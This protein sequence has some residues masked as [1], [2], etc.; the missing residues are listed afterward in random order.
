MKLRASSVNVYLNMPLRKQPLAEIQN[1]KNPSRYAPSTPT[2][3]VL[4]SSEAVQR[5]GQSTR[6]ERL[7]TLACVRT[8][9]EGY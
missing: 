6:E 4:F 7:V 1:Y 5:L 8:R 2:P 3:S 9:Q